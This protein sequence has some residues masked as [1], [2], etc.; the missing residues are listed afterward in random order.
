MDDESRKE[1]GPSQN[2]GGLSLS[3]APAVLAV[4]TA[5]GLM[6]SLIYNIGYFAPL[7]LELVSLLTIRDYLEGTLPFIV[8]TAG[9]LL[10]SVLTYLHNATPIPEQAE[11]I[12]NDLREFGEKSRGIT[13]R[14]RRWSVSAL[15][16]L[17]VIVIRFFGLSGHLV[18]YW[19]LTVVFTRLCRY[20]GDA[21]TISALQQTVTP[22]IFFLIVALFLDIFVQFVGRAHP[23]RRY[24]FRVVLWLS[25]GTFISGSVSSYKA[26]TQEASNW[27]VIG[28]IRLDD[29]VFLRSLD[30]GAIVLTNDGAALRFVRWEGIDEIRKHSQGLALPD[31]R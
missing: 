9:F 28:R 1:A 8:I 24:M 20:A 23:S 27:S 26:S 25:V 7:G 11:K 18:V 14:L 15:I 10:L 2:A 6:L 19:I 4:C 30:R 16:F 17:V 22:S 12:R 31:S 29:A 13:H 3:D 5:I 21:L